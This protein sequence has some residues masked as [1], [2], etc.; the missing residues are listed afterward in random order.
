MLIIIYKY[1]IYDLL[2][3][4]QVRTKVGYSFWNVPLLEYILI[5]WNKP[6]IHTEKNYPPIIKL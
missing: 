2:K 4:R 5:L 6:S 3:D 1:T